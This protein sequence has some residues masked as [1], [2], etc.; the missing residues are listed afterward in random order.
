VK[1]VEDGFESLR[2]H[3][4]FGTQTVGQFILS[5][6]IIDRLFAALVPNILEPA[7]NGRDIR[8]V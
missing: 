3:D 5:E 8:L 6:Q 2:P 1:H 7:P 4:R